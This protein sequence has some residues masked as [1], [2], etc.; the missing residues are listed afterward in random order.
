MKENEKDIV[1]RDLTQESIRRQQEI[2]TRLLEAEKAEQE[3]E[4]DPQRESEQGRDQDHPDPARYFEYQQQRQREAEMLRT[5]PPGL[6]PYY[7]A[8][9]D[10]YFDTFGRTR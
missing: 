2:R 3:R 10:R 5:V 4:L 9:V 1:N 6:K 8:R 7:K